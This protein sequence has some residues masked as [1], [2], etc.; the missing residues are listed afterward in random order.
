REKIN[1][2][3]SASLNPDFDK[4]DRIELVVHG[5]VIKTISSAKGATDLKLDVELQTDYGLWL[6]VRAY[7]KKSTKA[8]SGIVYVLTENREGFWNYERAKELVVGYQKRIVDSMENANMN[9]PRIW[10]TGGRLKQV[11][12]DALPSNKKRAKAATEALSV[13][14]AD[15]DKNRPKTIKKP[16]VN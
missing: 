13:R 14:L 5:K 10:A 11:W 4:L 8:H 12:E 16:V 6:A 1:I 15:I 7:G 3:A 2:S 9:D